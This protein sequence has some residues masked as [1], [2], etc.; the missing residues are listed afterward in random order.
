MIIIFFQKIANSNM[1]KR[2]QANIDNFKW[3][4]ENVLITNKYKKLSI[5]LSIV[6]YKLD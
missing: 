1:K 6:N 3:W 4:C 5:N 2:N